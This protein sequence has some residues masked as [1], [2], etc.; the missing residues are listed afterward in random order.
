MQKLQFSG[1]ESFVC[2]QL[3]L[4]KGYDFVIENGDFSSEN[5]VIQLGVGK[6]MV[7]SIAHWLKAFNIVDADNQPTTL[8]RFLFDAE[9]GADKYLEHLC[10][11]WL[12]HYHLVKTGKASIYYLFFNE[13]R[14]GKP[15]FTK[16]QLLS[17]I[18]H[19]YQEYNQ[20]TSNDNTIMSDINLFIRH[21]LKPLSK[22]YKIDI[23]E[24]FL[25]LMIDLE[26]METFKSLDADDHLVDWYKVENKLQTDIPAELILYSILD[27]DGYG[28][29][30]SLR[31]LLVGP[32]SPGAIFMLS[33][34]GL[35]NKLLS[36]CT[37]D[38]TLTDTA[39][40]RELQFKTKPNKWNI[41]NGYYRN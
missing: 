8:G 11:I 19:K 5:A 17:F 36:M 33:E 20:R 12:L 31:D 9:S 26:V 18:R 30:I 23:E 15:E 32:N 38:I 2:K 4:K 13:F 24:D 29:S 7:G 6:N 35:Y 16:P 25:G 3:W 27:N 22:T 10:S 37:A 40:I 34:E 28:D 1:H 14:K 41:L 21:Y 39:G